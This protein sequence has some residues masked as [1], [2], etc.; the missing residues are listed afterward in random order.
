MSSIADRESLLGVVA[1]LEA[2]AGDACRLAFDALTN[3]ERLAVLRR[4]ERVS[5]LLAVPQ[6][7]AVQQLAEQASPRELGGKDLPEVLSLGLSI[8]RAEARR[9]I[10]QAADLAP[11]R[12][13]DGQPLEPRLAATAAAQRTGEIGGEHISVIRGFLADLPGEVDP[14]TREAAER[15]LAGLGKSLSPEGLRR[16]ADRL[17]ALINPD[18]RYSDADRARRRGVNLGRQR[19]DGLSPITGMLDP[20]ARSYLEAVLGAWAAPGKCNPDDERPTVDGEPAEAVAARDDR[21]P[22]QRN[23]DAIKAALRAILAS[24][25]LGKH[26]GLPVSVV[27]ST[28]LAE[29]QSAAG[30]AVTAAGSLLPMRDLIRM[31]GHAYHYLCVFDNHS[32]RPLYLGRAKRIASADQRLVLHALERGCTFPGCSVSGDRC[33]VHHV[34][35]W[36]RGGR[37]DVDELTFGCQPHHELATSGGWTTRKDRLGR[38]EWIPPPHLPAKPATNSY[39]HPERLLADPDECPDE[40]PGEEPGGERSAGEAGAA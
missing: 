29:L 34:T 23:H 28:T 39:H 36:A 11:R 15:Q 25:K 35:D 31:A 26:R 27:V 40:C 6:Q 21:S 13:L 24:G 18:G 10:G 17:T 20:E 38:T 33:E 4:L 7:A 14:G 8:S 3:P 19:A 2:A 22:L 5:R 30:K 9:R 32:S 1:G 37:T 12:A 16:C